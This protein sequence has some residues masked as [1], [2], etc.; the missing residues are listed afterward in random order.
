[1]GNLQFSRPGKIMKNHNKI[2]HLGKV[3]KTAS[4]SVI[5][6]LNTLLS[7]I[8]NK[9]NTFLYKKKFFFNNSWEI[10]LVK[11]ISFL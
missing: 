2:L 3:V 10:S 9:L 4:S 5:Y 6:F 11:V 1:M 8:N 7:L